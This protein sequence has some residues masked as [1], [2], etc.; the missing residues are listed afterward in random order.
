MDS[1]KKKDSIQM[2]NLKTKNGSHYQMLFQMYYLS[3]VFH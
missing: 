3:Q 2:L 1:R